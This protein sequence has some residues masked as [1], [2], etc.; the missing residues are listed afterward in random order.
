[1]IRSFGLALIV[2]LISLSLLPDL[3]QA[4]PNL[5]LPKSEIVINQDI[6]GNG[7]PD[8]IIANYFVR[9]VLVPKYDSNTCHTI[10]G[11]FVRY[12]LFTD[13]EK[14]GEVILE[15]SYGTSLASY[16]VHKLTVDQDIDG[17]RRKELL[18]YMGD[19]TSQNSIY[20]FLKS[21]GVKAVN[22]GITDLP[23]ASLNPRLDLQF[24]RGAVIANW[25]QSTK[26]WKSPNKRYGWVLGDCVAIREQPDVQSKI[27]SM[28]SKNEILEVSQIDGDWAEV[29]FSYQKK[30]WINIKNL[31]FTSP[32]STTRFFKP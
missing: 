30:G 13:Q 25:D 2:G 28:I 19:D 12:T 27:V 29:Q 11:K 21:D 32:A 26:L 5:D 10:T 16:W 9:P 18:F 8:L 14:T 1:M 15:E 3:V 20:L 24:F 31:S 7:K 23:G 4:K 17:D 6:D 22:L